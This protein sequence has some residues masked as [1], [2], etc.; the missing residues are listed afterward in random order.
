MLVLK[1]LI[2]LTISCFIICW[3]LTDNGLPSEKVLFVEDLLIHVTPRL[4][5]L[6]CTNLSKIDFN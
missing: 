5:F 2:R 3:L 4:H 6:T 1:S